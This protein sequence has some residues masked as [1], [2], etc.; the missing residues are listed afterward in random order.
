M[1]EYGQN[2]LADPRSFLRKTGAGVS[3][4]AELKKEAGKWENKP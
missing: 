4:A 1:V 3:G 2:K